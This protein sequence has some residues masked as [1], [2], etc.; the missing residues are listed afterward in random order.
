MVSQITHNGI[1]IP[2]NFSFKPDDIVSQTQKK[3][4]SDRGM[5]NDSLS[6]LNG[7]MIENKLIFPL[8]I[9]PNGNI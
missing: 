4:Y 1:D 2:E 9:D 6:V 5:S 3:K 8:I 7:Y